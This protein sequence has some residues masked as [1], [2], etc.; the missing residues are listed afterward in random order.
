[1][2]L[3]LPDMVTARGGKLAED[4]VDRFLNMLLYCHFRAQYL[5]GSFIL[6]HLHS[7]ESLQ[8]SAGTVL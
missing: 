3:I 4:S 2:V 5:L 6:L 8:T 7:K 1:M